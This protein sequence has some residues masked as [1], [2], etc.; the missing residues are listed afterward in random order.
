MTFQLPRSLQLHLLEGVIGYSH[1]HFWQL[2]SNAVV[3][4][5]HV[6]VT[7]TSSEQKI[8]QA[9]SA[10]L[11]EAGA[12]NLTVQVE[13]EPFTS[14]NLAHSVGQHSGTVSV[15]TPPQVY[16]DYGPVASDVTAI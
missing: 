10:V 8:A 14:S 7:P 13:K 6:Q 16:V 2:S 9:V 5:I 12:N 4:T 11:K 15:V 3:G 1:A